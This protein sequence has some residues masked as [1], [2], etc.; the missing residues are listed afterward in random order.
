MTLRRSMCANFLLPIL[1]QTGDGISDLVLVVIT[2]RREPGKYL[3]DKNNPLITELRNDHIAN[4]CFSRCS[5]ASN[6]FKIN[7]P[8]KFPY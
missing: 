8:H 7:K 4:G 3:T 2:A 1:S 6:T 5:T